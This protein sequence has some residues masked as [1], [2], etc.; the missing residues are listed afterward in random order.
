MAVGAVSLR[1]RSLP[2]PILHWDHDFL[3]LRDLMAVTISFSCWFEDQPQL[4]LLWSASVFRA[5]IC[6]RLLWNAPTAIF[7]VWC[8]CKQGSWCKIET[9]I[10]GNKAQCS[11]LFFYE[12]MQITG[13]SSKSSQ[14][15]LKSPPFWFSFLIFRWNHEINSMMNYE[16]KSIGL[17]KRR[18]RHLGVVGSS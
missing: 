7:S 16:F 11:A 6:S 18:D 2:H 15:I 1:V 9:L 5:A 10:S 4:S 8:K 12:V 13:W 3:F 14:E 17:W